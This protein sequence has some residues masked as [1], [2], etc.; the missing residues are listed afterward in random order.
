MEFGVSSSALLDE[1]VRG[2]GSDEVRCEGLM[3]DRQMQAKTY[4]YS[5]ARW[6]GRSTCR[7]R[8][9]SSQRAGTGGCLRYQVS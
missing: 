2:R 7:R 4:T 1:I 6:I 3:V 9:S 8:E 5:T